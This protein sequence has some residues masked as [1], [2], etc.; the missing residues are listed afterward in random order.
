[1]KM[2]SKLNRQEIW[3]HSGATR[4]KNHEIAKNSQNRHFADLIA[5]EQVWISGQFNFLNHSH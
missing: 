1:M 5:H 2:I 4:P 3:P